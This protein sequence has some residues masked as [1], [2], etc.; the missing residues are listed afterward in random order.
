MSIK[1]FFLVVVT[2]LCLAALGVDHVKEAAKSST[3]ASGKDVGPEVVV[4]YVTFGDSVGCFVL[5]N[6]EY[7]VGR[8]ESSVKAGTSKESV[9]RVAGAEEKENK[10]AVDEVVVA[11]TCVK[12]FN[13]R[14]AQRQD[15]RGNQ[16]G[17][18]RLPTAGKQFCRFVDRCCGLYL[19][20]PN[21]GHLGFFGVFRLHLTVL[22][23]HVN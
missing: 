6:F 20:D 14:V 18:E 4:E 13:G 7:D 15:H 8:S 3:Q 2:A 12:R 23:S 1:Q 21:L 22:V 19:S 5:R 16:H 11:Q 9:Q 17:E 10:R